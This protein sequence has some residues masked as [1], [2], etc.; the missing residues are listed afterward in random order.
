MPKRPV[1][2]TQVGLAEN[3]SAVGCEGGPTRGVWGTSLGRDL[4]PGGLP[5]STSESHQGVLSSTK[6]R[7]PD[8]GGACGWGGGC[9]GGGWSEGQRGL[10]QAGRCSSQSI[11]WSL[12]SREGRRGWG[13]GPT[14][15]LVE[16]R[17]PEPKAPGQPL[18]CLPQAP[19]RGLSPAL[20]PPPA[21][22][23]HPLG[24]PKPPGTGW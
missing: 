8:G 20:P 13:A 1:G 16:R 10:R 5:S 18:C 19:S 23:L 14:P 21:R 24:L 22:S 4:G 17:L 9:E 7:S 11:N 3:P 15:D 6:V 12:D 2:R